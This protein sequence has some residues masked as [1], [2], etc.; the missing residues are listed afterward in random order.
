MENTF[1]ITQLLNNIYLK[2]YDKELLPTGTTYCIR[3][4][5]K[6]KFIF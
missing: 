1:H 4:A 6:C 2:E 3:L 5:E